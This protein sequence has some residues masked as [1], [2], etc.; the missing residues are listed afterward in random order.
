LSLNRARSEIQSLFEESRSIGRKN[1]DIKQYGAYYFPQDIV[2][3]A[4]G[5]NPFSVTPDLSD[6]GL[7]P[8]DSGMAWRVHLGLS[9]FPTNGR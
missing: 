7:G 5:V 3:F 9:W 2:S 8:V 4:V 1:V 6:E